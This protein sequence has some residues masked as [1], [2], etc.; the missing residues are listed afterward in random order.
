MR[1]CFLQQENAVVLEVA[2]TGHGIPA[3]YIPRLGHLFFTT[4]RDGT[5]LGLAICQQIVQQHGG[6]MEV[7]S[8]EGGGT[9]FTVKL[10]ACGK[11]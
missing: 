2:D 7:W 1:T 9:C 6:E 10:P 11:K 5:G 4:K 8:K 3:E